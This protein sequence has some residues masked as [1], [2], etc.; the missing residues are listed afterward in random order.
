MATQA[1][2]GD[3]RGRKLAGARWGK[4]N[5]GRNEDVSQTLAIW[6]VGRQWEGGESTSVC[7][8]AIDFGREG[9]N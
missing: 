1:E 9:F 2:T 4:A 8:E 3:R 5:E 6:T 7:N